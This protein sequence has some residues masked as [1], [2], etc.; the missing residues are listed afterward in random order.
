MNREIL[1]KSTKNIVEYLERRMKKKIVVTV[2]IVVMLL[3]FG[4]YLI[5]DDIF[6][7]AEPIVQIE[8]GM[9]ESVSLYNNEDEEIVICE[10]ELQKFLYYINNA[11]ATRMMSANDYPYIRPYYL[12]E[13]KTMERVFRY[14]AYEDHGTAYIELPYEGI[15]VVENEIVELLKQGERR[16]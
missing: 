14:M 16:K 5:L 3:L 4:G 10:S 11:K 6:P 13:I 7:K 8:V 15:Y 2:V 9:I 1:I 12:I